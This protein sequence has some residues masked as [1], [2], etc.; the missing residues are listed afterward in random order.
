MTIGQVYPVLD[1][2]FIV[3]EDTL[4]TDGLTPVNAARASFGKRKSELDESDIKLLRYLVKHKHFSPLR[5][6]YLQ[7]HIKMPEMVSRQFTKHQIGCEWGIP[8]HSNGWNE[9][10]R[11]Y[12][13][14]DEFYMPSMW[15]LQSPSNKQASQLDDKGNPLPVPKWKAYLA[16]R[17]YNDT[18]KSL[19]WGIQSLIKLGIAKE[20]AQTLLP[21]SF[22]TEVYWTASFQAI[23]NLIELRDDNHAQWEIRQ[24]AKVIKEIMLEHYPITTNAWFSK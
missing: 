19:R 10:S 24:Y 1:K 9:L 15:R 14:V 12:I 7:F 11:R 13:E 5:Q 3:L 18:T 21:I 2:G 8:S 20:M 22:Y 17:I 6:I 4:G 16:D 23:M